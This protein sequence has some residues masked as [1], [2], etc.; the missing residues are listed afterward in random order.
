MM[1]GT[2]VLSLDLISFQF[3]VIEECGNRF[4][5]GQRILGCL[6]LS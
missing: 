5:G 4:L 6:G 2:S 3:E 1:S